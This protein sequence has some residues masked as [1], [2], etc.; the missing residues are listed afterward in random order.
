MLRRSAFASFVLR[1]LAAATLAGAFAAAALACGGDGPKLVVADPEFDEDP[2]ETGPGAV[3][4]RDASVF[5]GG[6]ARDDGGPG[7]TGDGAAPRDASA[8]AAAVDAGPPPI[9]GT[10]TARVN[11]TSVR[12]TSAVAKYSSLADLVDV[13]AAIVLPSG[14]AGRISLRAQRVRTGCDGSSYVST[15]GPSFGF[16]N[17]GADCGLAITKFSKVAGQRIAATYDGTVATAQDVTP[18]S[19]RLVFAFDLEISP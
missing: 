5:E 4:A 7:A 15:G 14:A 2:S 9:L 1:P 8:D 13:D 17:T 3:A 11:G 16:I 18:R 12:V 6:L 19:A 10:Y